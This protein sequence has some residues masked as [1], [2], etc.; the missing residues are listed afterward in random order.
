MCA[1]SNMAVF[2]IFLISCF[3]SMLLRYF[4]NDF[5]MVPLDPIITG[6]TFV[7]AFHIC[8]ISVVGLYILG[9]SQLLS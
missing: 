6:I 7:F 1:V 4:L 3:P 5:E 2:Y 8:C 9:C